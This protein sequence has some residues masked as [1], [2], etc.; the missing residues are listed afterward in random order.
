L[1][2]KKGNIYFKFF[3]DKEVVQFLFVVPRNKINLIIY[4]LHSAIFNAHLDV[5]K[6]EKEKKER[7]SG[8]V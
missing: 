4:H 1:A 3:L 8:V 2:I 7:F 5:N 6:T